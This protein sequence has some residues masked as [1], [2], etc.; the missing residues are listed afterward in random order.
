MYGGTP[1]HN[2]VSDETGL[3]S[4]WDVESGKNILWSVPV[5]SQSYGGPIVAGGRVYVGTNN[6]G[7][8]DPAVKGDK[9]VLMAFAEKDGEFLWQLVHDK[10]PDGRI[11][12][13]PLQGICSTP[14]IEGDKLYYVSNRAQIVCA[15]VDGFGDGVNDGPF[16]EEKL[17]GK[18]SGDILWSYDMIGE[19]DVFPHNLAAGSPL[20]V[21]DILYTVT[22]NGVDEGHVNVPSPFAPSLV[23][24]NKKTGELLWDDTAPGEKILHGSWS[25]PSYGVIK[26]KPQVIYPGGDGW[27]YSLEPKTGKLIWKFDCNP[28]DSTWRLGGAGTRNNIISTPVIFDDKV[29]IAVGQDPEHGEA[30]GHFWVIDATMTG[31][32]TDK[33]KVWHRGGEDFHRS[34]SSVAIAEGIVYAADLSGFLYALDAKTGAHY[35]T[36]DTFAA[37]WSSP[38]VVDGKVYLGDEDGDVVV[39]KAGKKMEVLGE[40]NMGAAVYTTPVAHNGTLFVLSRK[41]LFAIKEGAGPKP[42]PAKKPAAKAAEKPAKS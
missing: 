16:K 27:V 26:G 19:V 38:Y 33:A 6:E 32:V 7:V 15:D 10:L 5:G 40:Y 39:L 17:T 24:V 42:K 20:I 18:K 12:D 4:Q 35:W 14:Y 29:Y 8:R 2:M 31:D 41:Q 30:P 34:I 25:N 37:V 22:G 1:S 13:W 28:K 11:H 3:P 36:Y 23:A 21:G 9:G